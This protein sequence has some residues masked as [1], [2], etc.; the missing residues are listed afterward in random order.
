MNNDTGEVACIDDSNNHSGRKYLWSKFLSKE[1]L[2]RCKELFEKYK[3]E[4]TWEYKYG[5]YLSRES[6]WEM[7]L[8]SEIDLAKLEEVDNLL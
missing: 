7:Y 2:S 4:S 6:F 1:E 5:A 8:N 3:G